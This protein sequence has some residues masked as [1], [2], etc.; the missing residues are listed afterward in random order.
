M[1]ASELLAVTSAS[2]Y[3]G[4][5]MRLRILFLAIPIGV[6][7]VGC[8]SAP[9]I[10]T[11]SGELIDGI[12]F[13]ETFPLST[14]VKDA[15]LHGER[16]RTGVALMDRHGVFALKGEYRA[17]GVLDKSTLTIVIKPVVGA[18]RRVSFRSC[19]VENVCAFF[20]EATAQGV[21]EHLP[22][23]CR[24]AVPCEKPR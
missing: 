3:G 1:A 4:R 14:E 2:R 17:S 21:V 19:S 16:L 6:A 18:E 22:I 11:S 9:P 12:T 8:E 15:T 5:G 24:N 13:E 10:K 23:V 20:G 7:G